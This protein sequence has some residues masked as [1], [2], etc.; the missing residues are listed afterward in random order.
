MGVSLV[1][2]LVMLAAIIPGPSRLYATTTS[3]SPEEIDAFYL[4]EQQKT[5]CRKLLVHFKLYDKWKEIRGD[6]MW[7]VP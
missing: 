7:V 2:T 5:V 4:K 6:Q 3:H 1:Y